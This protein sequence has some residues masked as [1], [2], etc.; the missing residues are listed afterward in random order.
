MFLY[1]FYKLVFPN[2]KKLFIGI[3]MYIPL[4]CKL[5][6]S[7]KYITKT[8]NKGHAFVKSSVTGTNA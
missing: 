4:R 2:I 5:P 8:R 7:F 3:N 1:F 6:L